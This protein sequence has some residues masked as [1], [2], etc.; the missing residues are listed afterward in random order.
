MY[1]KRKST[2]Y[3]PRTRTLQQLESSRQSDRAY[4]A[5]QTMLL[6]LEIPP[7][8]LLNEAELMAQ[9]GVGRTPLR[10][11]VQRLVTDGLLTV[12]PRR[13]TQVTTISGEDLRKLSEIRI[14]LEI[15][16]A[17]LAAERATVEDI[18]A[19]EAALADSEA[20]S[21][22][23]YYVLF[24]QQMHAL[25]ARAAQNRYLSD[26]LSR[27]YTLSV[28]LFYSARFQRERLEDMRKE[29][30]AVLEAIRRRDPLA[31]GEA[32]RFH[33]TIRRIFLGA[34]VSQTSEGSEG[35]RHADS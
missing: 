26:F 19:M 29:H 25:I 24:D 11:A 21:A 20:Q 2:N 18:C 15:Q 9:L 32:M 34:A 31:A 28:R 8:R 6:T 13:G 27:L 5:L 4:H 33:L 30:G 16:A 10:E 35:S 1:S 7:G 12:L 14:P 22:P 17:Q 23:D 3:S